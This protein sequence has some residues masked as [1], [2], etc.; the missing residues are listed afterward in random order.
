MNFTLW[1]R[2]ML[3]ST[4]YDV[5]TITNV[6]SINQVRF[7]V[8]MCFLPCKI[9]EVTATRDSHFVFSPKIVES[10]AL[11]GL[12]NRLPVEPHSSTTVCLCCC[13]A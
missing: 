3:M 12:R 8:F 13:E 5:P 7:T 4:R 11:Q 9:S 2:S 10:S 6:N 1:M